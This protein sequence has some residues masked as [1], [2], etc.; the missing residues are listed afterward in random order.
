MTAGPSSMGTEQTSDP[1][2]IGVRLQPKA[3]YPRGPKP[4]ATKAERPARAQL[5]PAVAGYS[6]TGGVVITKNTRSRSPVL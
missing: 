1:L 6:S 5:P 4:T 2:A 3:A